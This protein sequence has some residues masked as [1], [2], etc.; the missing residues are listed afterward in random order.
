M[1][2]DGNILGFATKEGK[3]GRSKGKKIL[4]SSLLFHSFQNL[5]FT[6]SYNLST[7]ILSPLKRRLLVILLIACCLSK[8][9]LG[10]IKIDSV[11]VTT[12]TCQNNGSI[13]VYV[14]TN[15]KLVLYSIV[16]GPVTEANQT[17]NVFNSLPPGSY[18]IQVTDGALDKVT[19]DV[20]I[21]GSYTSL[22]FNPIAISPYCA[23]SSDGKLIGNRV[24]GTGSEP[25][26][27]QLITPSKVVSAIQ[28]TDTFNNLP[29]GSY[30]IKLTDGCGSYSTQPKIINKPNTWV[31][32][33]EPEIEKVGCDSVLLSYQISLPADT[34]GLRRLP[35]TYMYQTKNGTFIPSLG[36]PTTI[37][38]SSHIHDT[39]YPYFNVQQLLTNFNYG[40]YVTVSVYNSCGD[41]GIISN[42]QLPP[43]KLKLAYSYLNCS[44]SAGISYIYSDTSNNIIY[45]LKAPVTYTVTDV[46]TNTVIANNTIV[47]DPTHNPQNIIYSL[48]VSG[49]YPINTIF[50]LSVTDGC[51]KVYTN[52]DAIPP[53]VDTVSIVSKKTDRYTCLD[54]VAN[55]TV[56]TA[57]FDASAFLTVLSGPLVLGSTKPGYS[58]TDTYNYPDTIFQNE[59][60]VYTIKNLTAGI[61]HFKVEDGCGRSLTDTFTVLTTNVSRL[62]RKITIKKGCSNQN[63][64]TV[65]CIGSAENIVKN[66]DNGIV[67]SD[68][69]LSASTNSVKNLPSGKYSISF[70]YYSSQFFGT[71]INNHQECDTITDTITI[72]EYQPPSVK[73]TNYITCNDSIHIELIPDSSKGVTP[74]KYEIYQGQ[75]TFPSQKSNVF[76][77]TKAGTY[78]AR[79]IDAC[80]SAASTQITVDTISFPP[81][82]AVISVCSNSIKLYYDSSAFYKYIW[83][84][85]DN[86]PYYGDTIS[87][88]YVTPADTGVYTITKIVSINGC[89]DT[90]QSSYHL[91][92][93]N[94]FVQNNTICKG[95]T[96]F[97]GKN[98][99]TIPGIYVDTLLSIVGN[100]DS[101]IQSNIAYLTP[102]IKSETL[103]SCKEVSFKG[104]IYT[105]STVLK[106]T[107]RS[108]R[109]CDSLYYNTNIVIA[110]I[111]TVT[112]NLSLTSCSSVL[113]EKNSYTVSTVVKDT[114][115]NSKGCDSIYTIAN[116]TIKPLIPNKIDTTVF[117]CDSVVYNGNVFRMD[118]VAND[119]L[120]SF[121]G[122][123]SIYH[124]VTI[125]VT[126]ATTPSVK[127]AGEDTICMGAVAKFTAS[128]INGGNSP[129]YHWSVDGI[130][131]ASKDSVFTGSF[132]NNS[133]SVCCTI[134]SNDNCLTIDSA[135]SNFIK[136][137]VEP[138][139]TPL[140][141]IAV[142]NNEICTGNEVVFTAT[143]ING[144]N[145]PAYQWEINNSNIGSNV[146]T[147]ASSTLSNGDNISCIL[148]S[149]Q[150]CVTARTA[151]STPIEISVSEGNCDTLFVPSAFAPF[152]RVTAK[153][154]ILRPFSNGNTIKNISF[155][156]YNRYGNLIFESH[157]LNG[158]W[159]GRINGILQDAGTFVWALEYI[160]SNGKKVL[161]KGTSV[162]IY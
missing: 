94:Y 12:S 123:D 100:C 151:V 116:I 98:K 101:I 46:S 39:A 77:V 85:P 125:T 84:K 5:I 52:L 162:L 6:K 60:G 41:E 143:A 29:V 55:M 11:K 122:C 115:R 89:I 9:S 70:Y 105:F 112:K 131:A 57:G 37:I 135:V 22:A 63:K 128:A 34:T 3:G 160:K 107:I 92:G 53:P 67:Y 129:T 81:A 108:V 10:A 118:T 145:N 47:G 88:P 148:T 99:Y 54:S 111:A 21:K 137:K 117:G 126:K 48:P 40:D 80:G 30:T 36:S 4:M 150:T 87:I 152:S 45:G 114:I 130:R 7:F 110:P 156:V 32:V 159:D 75:K 17:N 8:T 120:H 102:T 15:D 28:T 155:R 33:F 23:N 82:N 90:L 158:G 113:Y 141:N 16:S 44:T 124:K 149:N 42:E 27:W 119:T 142:T 96:V 133:D 95:D 64:I 103:T 20:T 43:Y 72:P 97:V 51:G 109:G 104:N 79:I 35:Y 18:T 106:D 61:Y 146:D 144:G 93:G 136:L 65:T 127:I 13:T 62:N 1:T 147:F 59:P 157:D 78:Y 38:D 139:V 134:T 58:Y 73:S 71:S 49:T 74:Y 24:A 154:Q 66:I 138:N 153:D 91:Y 161:T 140:I 56:T 26:T 2:L 76:A 25:F 31:A 19:K 121:Q 83:I 14:T 69:L 68:V 132:L 50:Q 86:K